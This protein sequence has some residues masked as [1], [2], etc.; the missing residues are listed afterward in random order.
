MSARRYSSQDSSP[1]SQRSGGRRV[2]F[3]LPTKPRRL[4]EDTTL[5]NSYFMDGFSDLFSS[6][7]CCT[8][9]K[10]TRTAAFVEVKGFEVATPPA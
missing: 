6:F 10:P 7:A 8:A 9:R 3:C 5:A 4:S 2:S 1:E